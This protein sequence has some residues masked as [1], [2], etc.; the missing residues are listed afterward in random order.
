MIRIAL[1]AI[2]LAC[3][4]ASGSAVAGQQQEIDFVAVTTNGDPVA[5]QV[6]KRSG[7]EQPTSLVHL[8][9]HGR[10]KVT[11]IHCTSG[12]QFRVQSQFPIYVGSGTWKDCQYGEIKFVFNEVAWGKDYINAIKTIDNLALKSEPGEIQITAMF[13]RS[14]LDARDYG[15]LAYGVAQLKEKLPRNQVNLRELDIVEKDSLAR[16]FGVKNGIQVGP[17]GQVAFSEATIQKFDFLKSKN[18]LPDANI[19][20]MDLKAFVAKKDLLRQKNLMK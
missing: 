13:A 5:G 2:V 17:N 1:T 14:A 11:D 18:K 10:K 15:K 12:L 7:N 19:N 6:M 4:A 8:D 3:L 16:A 20:T 9:E